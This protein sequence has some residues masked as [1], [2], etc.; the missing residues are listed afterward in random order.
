MPSQVEG[1]LAGKVSRYAPHG[2]LVQT[3]ILPTDLPTCCEFG[4]LNLD[5]L[6][7]TTAVLQRPKEHFTGQRHPGGLFALNVGGKGLPSRAF[8]GG[9]AGLACQSR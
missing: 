2:R 5:I 4:G 9:E 8:G 1:S 6:Y 7:V 3:M